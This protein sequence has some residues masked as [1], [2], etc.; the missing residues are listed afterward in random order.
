MTTAKAKLIR[1]RYLLPMAAE[2]IEDGALLMEAGRI[3]AVGPFSALRHLDSEIIDYG[4]AVILPPLVNAHCHLEL[5]NFPQWAKE[6]DETAA[7]ADFVGWIRRLIRV[8]HQVG[9]AQFS[10][11][12][13]TGIE[14]LLSSGTGAVGDILTTP[15]ALAPLLSSPLLGRIFF[16]TI[17]LEAE[18]FSPLLDAAL[19]AARQLHPPLRGGLSPHST[20]TI[21]AHHLERAITLARAAALPLAIHCGESPEESTFLQ[22]GNG[23]IATELYAAA[24]WPLP[25]APPRLSPVAWLA[26]HGG[27]S[28]Q[29]LL[30]HGVQVDA[31]DAACIAASGATVVLCPRSN[32]CLGVGTAPVALYK[33]AGVHLALG[34]DSLASNASLSLWDEIA[35]ARS[36]YPEFSPNELLDLATRGGARAL[37]LAAEMGALTAGSGAHFQVL[38][39][40]ALP[41]VAELGEWLCSA[42]HHVVALWL[43]GREVW[44][45]DAPCHLGPQR[46]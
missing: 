40:A 36:L 25:S 4:D 39:A 33:E 8:R 15:T 42:E 34:T 31:G 2:L 27:L 22:E 26:A 9:V 23:P 13:A 16:E 3:V 12:V 44:R 11:S 5:S 28:P 38:S 41:P 35:C 46:L 21:S 19:R 24:G 45:Q 17:G 29:T 37:G 18:N 30:I 1:A 14:Q 6:C 32:A 20:Y 7:P 10:L 43:S